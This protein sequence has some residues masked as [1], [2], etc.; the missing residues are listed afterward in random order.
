MLRKGS[1]FRLGS[2]FFGISDPGLVKKSFFET[3]LSKKLAGGPGDENSEMCFEGA[4]KR[5]EITTTLGGVPLRSFTQ[6]I[7]SS[8]SFE[9]H[10]I[11]DDFQN[12]GRS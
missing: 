9:D 1:E 8:I 4:G 10:Q 12:V 11:F 7:R 2:A 3:F 5:Q 6:C